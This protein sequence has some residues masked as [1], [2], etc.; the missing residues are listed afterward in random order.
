ML[1]FACS[2][3]YLPLTLTLSLSPSRRAKAPLRRDGGGERI[4]R[5][6]CA[7]CA[8]EPTPSPWQE[9]SRT[10]WRVPL[11]GGVRGGLVGQVHGQGTASA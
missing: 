5:I 2:T 8:P 7:H 3:K 9:G 4:P 6:V 11:L 10:D 1:H